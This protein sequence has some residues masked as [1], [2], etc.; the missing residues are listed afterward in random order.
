MGFGWAPVSLPMSP[1]P[2]GTDGCRS[3]EFWAVPAIAAPFPLPQPPSPPQRHLQAW[4]GASWGPLRTHHHAPAPIR[5]GIYTLWVLA[6]YNPCL[7]A[8]IS[9]R[10]SYPGRVTVG[11][12]Q[13]RCGAGGSE[14]SEPLGKRPSHRLLEV[15]VETPRKRKT[16]PQQRAWRY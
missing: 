8:L 1:N 16:H 4:H 11:Q 2:V 10:A 6:G 5:V 15:Q 14:R 7:L 12:Q 9:R 3:H 13:E